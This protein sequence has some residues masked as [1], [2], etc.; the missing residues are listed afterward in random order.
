MGDLAYRGFKVKPLLCSVDEGLHH[1]RD[2]S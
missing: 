1:G 2:I